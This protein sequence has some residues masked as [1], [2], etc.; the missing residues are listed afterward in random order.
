MNYLKCGGLSPPNRRVRKLGQA[1]A[2][3][4]CPAQSGKITV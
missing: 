2:P 4:T 1:T 3:R